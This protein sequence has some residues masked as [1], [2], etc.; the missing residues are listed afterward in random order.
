MYSNKE[1]IEKASWLMK[2]L[3]DKEIDKPKFLGCNDHFDF[4]YIPGKHGRICMLVPHRKPT[5]EEL[6]ELYRTLAEIAVRNYKEELST[7]VD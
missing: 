5:P 1:D 2:E 3:Q 7:N 4:V 6:T